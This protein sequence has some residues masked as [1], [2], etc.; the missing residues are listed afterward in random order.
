[1]QPKKPSCSILSAAWHLT[2]AEQ[3]RTRPQPWQQRQVEKIEYVQ[4]KHP[5][6][7]CGALAHVCFGPI[8]NIG[9]RLFDHAIDAQQYRRGDRETQSFDALEVDHEFEF[10]RLLHGQIGGLG[11]F[12]NP[13]HKD[14]TA[15]GIFRIISTVS[16]DTSR[17]RVFYGGVYR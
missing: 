16:D 12:E 9:S 2:P 15:A 5:P 4:T 10:D 7:V 6:C 14:G 11:A 13:V 1:M 3:P 8:A 17:F